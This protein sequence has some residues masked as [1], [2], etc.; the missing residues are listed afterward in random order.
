[1]SK[2]KNSLHETS[3]QF[4]SVIDNTSKSGKNIVRGDMANLH[5]FF[6]SSIACTITNKFLIRIKNFFS[7]FHILINFYRKNSKRNSIKY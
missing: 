2:K 7:L 5:Y 4:K 1:M 3:K 6:G